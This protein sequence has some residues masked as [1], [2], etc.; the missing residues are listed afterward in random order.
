[1]LR[2]SVRRRR[3][4][5][6]RLLTL[7]FGLSLMDETFSIMFLVFRNHWARLFN[8]DPEV[9]AMVASVLPLVAMYDLPCLEPQISRLTHV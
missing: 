6:V 7:W 5:E 4:L 8:E 3:Y 1:M 2:C 9:G